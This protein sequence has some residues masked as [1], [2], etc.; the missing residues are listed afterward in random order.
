MKEARVKEA[1]IGRRAGEG[2]S[3]SFAAAR[4]DNLDRRGRPY[5]SERRA[6][7]PDSAICHEL[8]LC[9]A[10][11]LEIHPFSAAPCVTPS[12]W[13]NNRNALKDRKPRYCSG[14]K[15][16]SPTAS[17]LRSWRGIAR[18]PT[19]P[20]INGT[21]PKTAAIVVRLRVRSSTRPTPCLTFYASLR[22]QSGIS[23]T[24]WSRPHRTTM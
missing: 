10:I 8:F 23:S 11:A 9:H 19:V 14:Q 20:G 1:R 13:R 18:A 24:S 17:P 7:S 22:A 21:P 3:P 15:V 5:A 2:A 6:A 12:H 16:T 4:R